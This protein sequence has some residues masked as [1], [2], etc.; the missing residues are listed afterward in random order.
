[1]QAWQIMGVGHPK[2][3]VHMG[4]CERTREERESVC[5]CVVSKACVSI[6]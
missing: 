4:E 5:E 6:K 2:G 1:M 3:K